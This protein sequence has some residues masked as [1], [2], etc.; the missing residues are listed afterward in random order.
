MTVVVE[1]D[2]WVLSWWS[3]SGDGVVVVDGTVAEVAAVNP[4][5]W[6]VRSPS[7]AAGGG[8]RDPADDQPGGTCHRWPHAAGVTAPM[9]AR[10][11]AVPP[12]P[13]RRSLAPD[14][15]KEAIRGR[16]RTGSAENWWR[17]HFSRAPAR[18]RGETDRHAWCNGINAANSSTRSLVPVCDPTPVRQ[19]GAPSFSQWLEIV[20][21]T[22]SPSHHHPSLPHVPSVARTSVVDTVSAN[23]RRPRAIRG[24]RRRAPAF[25]PVELP[26]TCPSRAAVDLRAS[27]GG[28]VA[29]P[30][31][32]M[33]S[34]ARPTVP[35]IA[36]PSEGIHHLLDRRLVDHVTQIGEQHPSC[37]RPH[38]HR[39]VLL[40]G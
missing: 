22:Q 35:E 12:A 37:L 34:R 21:G 27:R 19:A 11:A 14:M 13:L 7:R 39:L 5:R 36:E 17:V 3:S 15:V 28:G 2:A 6:S 16:A 8:R 26:H 29:V 10:V 20:N 1:A 40:S 24:A 32:T 38:R 9:S 25:S 23:P 18:C 4:A 30:T 33:S 31:A